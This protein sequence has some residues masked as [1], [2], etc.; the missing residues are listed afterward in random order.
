MVFVKHDAANH[1]LAK[2]FSGYETRLKI[3][4]KLG[5]FKNNSPVS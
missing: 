3:V 1:M 4:Y 2:L 5:D